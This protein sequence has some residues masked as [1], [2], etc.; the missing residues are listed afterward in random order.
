[1]A[2]ELRKSH[3]AVIYSLIGSYILLYGFYNMEGGLYSFKNN[4]T[5][6]GSL[7]IGLPITSALTFISLNQKIVYGT[8]LS[9]LP[10][11]SKVENKLEV[12]LG[13]A[14]M[15]AF[16]AF[17]VVILKNN[18]YSNFNLVCAPDQY[19]LHV[20][21]SAPSCAPCDPCNFDFGTC[22]QKTGACVCTIDGADPAQS[23][24]TCLDGFTIESN[25][26]VCRNNYDLDSFCTACAVGWSIDSDC[27]A[28]AT[29]W[30]GDNCDECDTGYFGNPS[31][32]CKPCDCEYG[33]CVSNEYQNATFDPTVC[34][35]TGQTC[36]ASSDC[37]TGNCA[38]VCRSQLQSPG[39]NEALEFDNKVC[40]DD[41]E[42]GPNVDFYY[43]RCVEKH[44]CLEYKYGTGY[45]I[46][47][48][49]GRKPPKC[50]LCPGYDSTYDVYCNGR[51]TC[52]GTASGVVCGCEEGH[53]GVACE[54]APN[55]EC[56]A[57]FF[58][59]LCEPCPGVENFNGLTACGIKSGN[60]TACS[61]T[62][63]CVCANSL[64]YSF[65]PSTSCSTC[66]PGY[67]GNQC[68]R[69]P[70][71][72]SQNPSGTACGGVDKGTCISDEYGRPICECNEG[73]LLNEYG[74]C[75]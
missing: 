16:I 31:V 12:I 23:C 25:C 28:C 63:S 51:G 62:G 68:L 4:F 30:T 60:A 53:S 54:R 9:F 50:A 8:F 40:R 55:M 38:G 37:E 64:Y 66:S 67:G 17:G 46:D 35:R 5:I 20:P 42:C 65:D 33:T 34:T 59:S 22:N 58:G 56:A 44:C 47:C 39:R 41:S 19:I 21:G 43:G 45:C 3:L 32:A 70:G 10:R 2:E 52:M 48:P 75:E 15:A 13:T 69:C 7:M 73:F 49:D 26:S 18:P 71:W 14:I 57:G 29:G 6:I 11:S 74:V 61:D 24:E 27:T 72:T 36:S 1:M